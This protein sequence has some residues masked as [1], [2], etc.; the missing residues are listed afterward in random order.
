MSGNT[1][2]AEEMDLDREEAAL[3]N[4]AAAIDPARPDD[5][6]Y[7]DDAN[8]VRSRALTHE[9]QPSAKTE[10]TASDKSTD[11]TAAQQPDPS[12]QTDEAAKTPTDQAKTEATTKHTDQAATPF[13]KERARLNETWKKV[14]A[15]KEQ[16]R[17]E[18]EEIAAER[19]KLTE[20]KPAPTVP[21]QRPLIDGADADTWEAVASDFQAEGNLQLA[22]KAKKNADKLREQEK[23]ATAAPTASRERFTAEEKQALNAEWQQ[24][25]AK[26]GKDNPELTQ[27]GT[28]LSK[29]VA[30]LLQANPLFSMRG[31]GINLAVEMAKTESRAAQVETL[32][33][34][35]EQ[36]EQEN[37]RLEGLTALP[38]GGGNPPTSARQFEDL[39][40]DEQERE[41]RAEAAA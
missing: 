6:T 2:S 5:A 11:A 41:L 17:R 25:L 36:L 12:K 29:R 31:D 3:R 15:E 22:A 9:A 34:R 35:I 1:K 38:S 21:E 24:N 37:K 30:E 13:Q 14:E 28:P 32:Q 18:R 40:L 19:R 16:L 4:E 27:E 33:K 7:H 23:A 8:P 26:L 20:A 10:R 39:S